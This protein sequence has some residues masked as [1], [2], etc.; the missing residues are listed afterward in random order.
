MINRE[1]I[2]F[3][4]DKNRFNIMVKKT[5][6]FYQIK[7]PSLTIIEKTD[8]ENNEINPKWKPYQASHLKQSAGNK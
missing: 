2:E 6:E 7:S 4:N 5:E 1:K 3:R 8:N